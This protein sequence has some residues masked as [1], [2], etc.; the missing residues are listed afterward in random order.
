MPDEPQNTT[1]KR[2]A[3]KRVEPTPDGQGGT[4]PP[5]AQA[6]MDAAGERDQ[7]RL[8]D[9]LDRSQTAAAAHVQASP[10]NAALA[11]FQA[12]AIIVAKAK[13]ANIPGKNGGQGYSYKYADL[14]ETVRAVMPSLTKHGLSFIAVPRI[15]EGTG[16]YELVG[17][18]AHTSGESIEGSLPLQGRQAQEL[19]SSITYA[20][21]YLL[22]C[23][24]GIV[25]DDDDDGTLAQA[26]QER[27]RV[28]RE[29]EAQGL[30]ARADATTILSEVSTIWQ[31]ANQR[32]LLDT[33]IE[34]MNGDQEPLGVALRRY[35]DGLQ[36]QQA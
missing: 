24:T 5:A 2:P 34:H 12:E 7:S 11:L 15:V 25:T 36:G 1:T 26:A 4:P 3:R 18:L 33:I 31:E 35:G 21:R 16:A 17:R 9:A 19:G 28:N 6:A 20:R 30:W 10:L 22:G 13:T 27:S 14:A 29:P 8:H 23:M 32:G